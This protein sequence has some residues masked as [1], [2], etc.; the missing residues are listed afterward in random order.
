MI[1][2][3]LL[4]GAV[5][6]S[7]VKKG[8]REEQQ[9]RQDQLSSRRLDGRLDV[10]TVGAHRVDST[11]AALAVCARVVFVREGPTRLRVAAVSRAIG[12][13]G[14]RALDDIPTWDEGIDSLDRGDAELHLVDRLANASES[15][16]VTFRIKTLG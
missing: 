1:S 13:I 7:S 11:L 4:G 2:L 12:S 14:F 9:Q 6:L 15:L 10:A 8:I 3:N 16:D 5:P